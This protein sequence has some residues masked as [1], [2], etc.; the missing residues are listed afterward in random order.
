MGIY[1]NTLKNPIEFF[2]L[3]H[4]YIF[5]SQYI[6]EAVIDKNKLKEAI[7]V[8]RGILRDLVDKIKKF[9]KEKLK[10]TKDRYYNEVNKNKPKVKGYYEFYHKYYKDVNDLFRVD[11]KYLHNLN[12]DNVEEYAE[13]IENLFSN[14]VEDRFKSTSLSDIQDMY[15]EFVKEE[16]Y[17]LN[18]NKREIKKQSDKIWGLI[19]D[20]DESM[21][22][23][24]GILQNSDF[25]ESNTKHMQR[26]IFKYFYLT[27]F[28][29]F[30][31]RILSEANKEFDRVMNE[32]KMMKYK[33]DIK[34][35]NLDNEISVS[36]I[37]AINKKDIK[38]VRSQLIFLLR[39]YVEYPGNK[40]ILAKFNASLG[41]ALKYKLDIYEKHDGKI[42]IKPG[43]CTEDTIMKIVEDLENNFS[44]E[45]VSFVLKEIKHV[46]K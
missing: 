45:R 5:E 39:R 36:Y 11:T 27:Q 12:K 13:K 15:D 23:L 1:G 16:K 46:Y 34:E 19:N 3:N 25:D 22:T 37:E 30:G 28:A 17:T 32:Y 42:D 6:T 29:H 20:L 44:K 31:M 33:E 18:Y 43:T 24:N 4:H 9:I 8:I 10:E 26:I 38:E 41:Y 7:E 40:K 2:D 14:R 21:N 35:K